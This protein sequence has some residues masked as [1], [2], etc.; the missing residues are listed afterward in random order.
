MAAKSYYV[1]VQVDLL[2]KCIKGSISSLSVDLFRMRLFHTCIAS[3]VT[4]LYSYIS[5]V[6]LLFC[7]SHCDSAMGFFFWREDFS[8]LFSSFK[9]DTL[10]YRVRALQEECGTSK[11]AAGQQSYSRHGRHRWQASA[12][13]AGFCLELSNVPKHP[14]S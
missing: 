2:L 5:Y 9:Q 14:D 6:A 13:N 8:P 12:K 10:V 11:S 1:L 3:T 4:Y 7:L